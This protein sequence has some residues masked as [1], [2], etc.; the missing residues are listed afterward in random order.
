MLARQ[1]TKHRRGTILLS[2][3]WQIGDDRNL[4]RPLYTIY[5]SSDGRYG[6]KESKMLRPINFPQPF[7]RIGDEILC[8]YKTII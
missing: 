1:Q 5:A 6:D 8:P 2:P 3:S 4:S 7:H